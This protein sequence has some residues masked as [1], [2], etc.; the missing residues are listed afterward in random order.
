MSRRVTVNLPD[1][2][3]ERLG[4]ESN[5]SAYVT[6]ALRQRIDSERTRALL[7]EHGF[8]PITDEG[9]ARAKQR[10]L[11]AQ[12]KLSPQRREELRRRSLFTP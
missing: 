12:A 6:E 1:D 4:E 9:V 11:A 10:R 3:A 7:V 8:P 2:V 5:A